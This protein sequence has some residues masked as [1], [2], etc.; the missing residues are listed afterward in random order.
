M[1]PEK[2][3]D[4]RLSGRREGEGEVE[5]LHNDELALKEVDADGERSRTR[6][7]HSTMKSSSLSN[8]ERYERSLTEPSSHTSCQ[9]HPIADAQ[10]LF[11]RCHRAFAV[12]T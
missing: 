10:C 7:L 12:P 2:G 4:G 1:W 5:G 8:G 11:Y 3:G 6:L 9:L